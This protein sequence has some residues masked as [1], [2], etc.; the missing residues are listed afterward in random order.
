MRKS[1][2]T[3]STHF[4]EK[5]PKQLTLLKPKSRKE[6]LS[7]QQRF[8]GKIQPIDK[9]GHYGVVSHTSRPI[10][11]SDTYSEPTIYNQKV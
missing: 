10:E 4:I 1:P 11:K 7:F 3:H 9:Q 2:T 8:K 6:P 5:T